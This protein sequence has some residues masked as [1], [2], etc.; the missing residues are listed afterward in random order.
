MAGSGDLS[1]IGWLHALNAS[2]GSTITG[3]PGIGPAGD[4][5]GTLSSAMTA[6]V[7]TTITCSAG[8]TKALPINSLLV[9]VDAAGTLTTMEMVMLTSAYAS[10]TTTAMNITSQTI[11]YTHAIGA[12]V[13]L[14]GF[15]P[16]VSL[17]TTAPT[18]HALGTEYGG[19]SYARQPLT[20]TATTV[21]DPP[22][23]ANNATITFGPI[24]GGTGASITNGAIMDAL[25]GGTADNMYAFYTWGTAKTPGVGDSVQIAAAAL[26]TAGS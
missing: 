21:A 17:N 9:V 18:S 19:T 12:L 13:Y 7:V 2:V 6:G 16:F 15:A 8:T 4:L 1:R 26:S 3:A 23:Q 22:V 5:V 24:T 10:G 14:V 25:S 11:K 20:S